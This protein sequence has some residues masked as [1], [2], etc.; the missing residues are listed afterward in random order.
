MPNTRYNEDQKAE[1]TLRNVSQTAGISTS[2]N[3]LE[4]FFYIKRCLN[5][6]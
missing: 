2:A 1:E 3:G 6:R 4:K 5:F